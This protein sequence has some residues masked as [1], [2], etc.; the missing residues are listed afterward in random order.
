MLYSQFS[1]FIFLFL[2]H[3]GLKSFHHSKYYKIINNV[4]CTYLS[5]LLL[6]YN[7]HRNIGYKC[8]NM[9]NYINFFFDLFK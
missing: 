3:M 4:L 6:K 5:I 2:F 1:Y 9:N 8:T 7:T